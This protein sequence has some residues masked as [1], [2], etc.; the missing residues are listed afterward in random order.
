[1]TNLSES[2][3]AGALEI[4]EEMIE[5]GSDALLMSGYDSDYEDVSSARAAQLV[6]EA[7]VL[8]YRFRNDGSG[9]P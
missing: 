6:L 2:R 4:T 9:R 3:Q 5:A 1:M 8:A 7:A